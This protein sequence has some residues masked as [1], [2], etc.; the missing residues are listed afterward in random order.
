MIQTQTIQ[1]YSSFL[2]S[3][4][5]VTRSNSVTTAVQADLDLLE[6]LGDDQFTQTHQGPIIRQS[7]QDASTSTVSI[8]G[9]GNHY[10]ACTQ[11]DFT[12]VGFDPSILP[13][14]VPG[15]MEPWRRNTQVKCQSLCVRRTDAGFWS[16]C[17]QRWRGWRAGANRWNRMSER[18]S[19][20]KTVSNSEIMTL[21]KSSRLPI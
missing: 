18:M 1:H 20:R 3:Y 12:D 15:W 6:V 21:K 10:H 9:S 2:S 19:Y 7:S 11:D 4:R 17:M 13:P 14:P 5:R 16:C 8:Q